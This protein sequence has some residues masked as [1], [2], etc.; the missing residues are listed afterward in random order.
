MQGWERNGLGWGRVGSLFQII[1]KFRLRVFV[2]TRFAF[3]ELFKIL[4]YPRKVLGSCL[5][6]EK[7][8]AGIRDTTLRASRDSW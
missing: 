3:L 7:T 5:V 4:E 1:M 2:V 6:G 8:L